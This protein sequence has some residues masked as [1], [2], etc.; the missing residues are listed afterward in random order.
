MLILNHLIGFGAADSGQPTTCTFL[1]NTRDDGNLTT[2][3]F[4]SQ[5]FGAADPRRYIIAAVGGRASAARTLDSVSIGGTNATQIAN[6]EVGT[7]G[8]MSIW[9]R[10]VPTGTSGDVVA[11]YSSGMIRTACALF[12]L[13]SDFD[14]TVSTDSQTD[15]V[16]SGSDLSVS[17]TVP[18]GGVAIAAVHT[19]TG[20]ASSVSWSGI[21]ESYDDA[22]VE[23]GNQGYSG[24]LASYTASPLTITSTIAGSP[25]VCAL[26]AASFR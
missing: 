17:L 18:V 26:A 13:L 8:I 20:V 24:G 21:S 23:L 12:R 1:Q 14:S 22:S 11:T 15:G 4:S 19:N 7:T 5:S 25:S 16:V 9:A 3:T 10:Y 2:Y 6:I